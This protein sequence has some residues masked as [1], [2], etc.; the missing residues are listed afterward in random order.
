MTELGTRNVYFISEFISPKYN[1]YVNLN[2]QRYT[3]T[4]NIFWGKSTKVY[5]ED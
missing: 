2:L 5:D 4:S 3:K 1:I